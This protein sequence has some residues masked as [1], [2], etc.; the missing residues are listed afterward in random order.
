MQGLRRYL[1]PAQEV[2]RDKD[3]LISADVF[4][5]YCYSEDMTC[6]LSN[7][8]T[9]LYLLLETWNIQCSKG[10][11]LI[12]ERIK[13]DPCID[14]FSGN[15]SCEC[16]F[17][18]WR[19]RGFFLPPSSGIYAMNVVFARYILTH[20]AVFRLSPGSRAWVAGGEWRGGERRRSGEG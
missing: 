12:T 1:C 2:Q 17:R 19:F 8:M 18:I 16:W 20:I 14:I 15:Q 11:Y 9:V 6:Y 5:C 4:F 7:I 10:F 13:Y 3:L